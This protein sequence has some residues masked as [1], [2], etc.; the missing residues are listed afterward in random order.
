MSVKY[1]PGKHEDKA[2][3]HFYISKT[4]NRAAHAYNPSSRDIETADPWDSL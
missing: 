2:L 3:I 1:R 4:L